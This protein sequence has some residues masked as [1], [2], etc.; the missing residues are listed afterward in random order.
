MAIGEPTAEM[1]R[2]FTLVLKGHIALATAV[3][4]RG[5][6]GVQ[7]DALAGA[8]CGKPASTTIT[9]PATGSAVA[10]GCTRGRPASPS[11]EAPLPWTWAWCCRTSP[12]TTAK[13]AYGIRIENLLAVEARPEIGD[14]QRP[15]LGFETLTLAPL[16]RRLIDGAVL[17]PAERQWV[18]A[19]HARVQAEIGPLLKDGDVR[20]WLETATRRLP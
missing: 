19:Y 6:A 7:L 12:A 16:D 14:G 1:R 4:P 5:T 18:D 8:R 2:H 15:F 9:A 13:G 10:W 17:T 3:F 20:A 11:E